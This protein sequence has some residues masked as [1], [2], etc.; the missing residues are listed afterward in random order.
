MGT[1]LIILL[2]LL[3]AK[4]TLNAIGSRYGSIDAL[5]DNSDLIETAFENTLSRDGTGPNNMES[6]L[7]M[8]SNRI[9]NLNN[10]V[11]PQDAVTKNQ[12]D[13]NKAEVNALV[14][15]LS[16]SPYGDAANVSYIPAGVSAVPTTVQTKLRETVSVKDFGAVGDGVTDDTAA[17]Q[18]AIDAAETLSV[19]NARG[20]SAPLL[21]SSFP[22]VSLQFPA[23]KYLV[24]SQLTAGAISSRYQWEGEN[25]LLFA[26][27]GTMVGDYLVKAVGGYDVVLS[28]IAFGSTE[29]G[30]IEFAAPNISSAMVLIKECNF[31][32]NTNSTNAGTAIKYNDQSSTLV[33]RD[34]LF[35]NVQHPF[36]HITGDFVTFSNCWFDCATAPNY[37]DDTG[38]FNVIKNNFAV[39]DCV[40]ASGPGDKGN[41]IAYFNCTESGTLLTIRRNRITFEFG[42][43]PIINWKIPLDLTN[44][45]FVRNGFTIDD[46]MV[47]PRGQNVTVFSTSA[48]PLVRL[49]EMPN[50]MAF[51]NLH[52]LNAVN[53]VIGFEPPSGVSSFIT[54]VKAQ[55][56]GLSQTSYTYENCAGNSMYLVQTTD[57]RWNREWLE[58]F[59]IFNY[60]VGPETAG[61]QTSNIYRTSFSGSDFLSS[62]EVSGWISMLPGAQFPKK[63]IVSPTYNASTGNYA[64]V[65]DIEDTVGVVN[66]RNVTLSP[67]FFN[68]TTLAYTDTIAITEDLNNYLFA[69]Q[70]DS[71]SSIA[72]NANP[73]YIRP[74]SAFNKVNPFSG[75][76]R[77]L[78]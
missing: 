10:G 77:Q 29:S 5:N 74:F 39:E 38:Y 54:A 8:D 52:W 44:G 25:A 36:E 49:Y 67:K 41:R 43:G 75:A 27:N 64:F 15:S 59:N 60:G 3:M 53:L 58:L 16:T 6:D 35:N 32:G 30:C 63:W 20:S 9:I 61:S 26:N 1:L 71:T 65:T 69:V 24:S 50:Y 47:S 76:P 11:H 40:F 23:G 13:T 46:C 14:Q 57:A 19:A 73:V 34:C 62:F 12:L 78:T 7:D 37:A 2:G 42:G 66:S 48:T 21:R 17:I 22:L 31:I 72:F 4:L 68:L 18:A 51:K 56:Q 45:S 70:I 28:D 55:I 33:V